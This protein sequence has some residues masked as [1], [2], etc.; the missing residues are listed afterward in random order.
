MV[1]LR[2]SIEVRAM[3]PVFGSPRGIGLLHKMAWPYS[4][5]TWIARDCVIKDM[6]V[7]TA[8]TAIADNIVCSNLT[9]FHMEIEPVIFMPYQIY[10]SICMYTYVQISL[11]RCI[12]TWRI[13]YIWSHM[14]PWSDRGCIGALVKDI[15][16]Y[17]HELGAYCGTPVQCTGNVYMI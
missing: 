15:Y 14:K 5:V 8:Y 4:A 1:T 3:P 17:A 2:S 11:W 9:S 16:I 7:C 10:S 6:N 12:R 13:Y